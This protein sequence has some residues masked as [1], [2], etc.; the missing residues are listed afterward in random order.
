M[1]RKVLTKKLTE[2]WP[3]LSGTSASDRHISGCI[4]PKIKNT[5]INQLE[6][7]IGTSVGSLRETGLSDLYRTKE[8]PQSDCNTTS[9][10]VPFCVLVAP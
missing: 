5:R 1:L 6:I 2:M 9:S 10:S 8:Y 3:A 7:S 4:W